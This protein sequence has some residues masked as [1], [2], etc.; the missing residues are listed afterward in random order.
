MQLFRKVLRYRSE[1]IGRRIVLNGIFYVRR[2]IFVE[3]IVS[4]NKYFISQ[5]SVPN[6]P[7]EQTSTNATPRYGKLQ[8]PWLTRFALR[9]C[10]SVQTSLESLG[11]EGGSFRYLPHAVVPRIKQSEGSRLASIVATRRKFLT[12]IQ[13][14]V[15][16]DFCDSALASL[17]KRRISAK[18]QSSGDWPL[19]LEKRVD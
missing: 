17:Q 1:N 14:V 16:H 2:K 13:E 3:R 11:V 10:C 6:V 19:F 7:R 5:A 18:E 15:L 12:A 9:L 4:S 8:R